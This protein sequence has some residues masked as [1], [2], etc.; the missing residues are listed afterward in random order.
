M[1]LTKLS[2]QV[3]DES[4]VMVALEQSLAMI[5]FN[6]QGDVLWANEN[7]AQAMGYQMS[8]LP[9]IHHQQFCTPDFVNSSEYKTLWDN[10]RK[11]KKF[12]EKIVRVTK[13]GRTLWLEATYMPIYNETEQV[14]AVLKVAT[15]ITAR[16]VA[17]TQ[18]TTELKEL[19]EDLLKRTEEGIKRN[20]Q[21]AMA[22]ERMMNDNEINLN[23]LHN[24]EQQ[25]IAIQRIV[26]TIRDFA[27]QANLLA[28]N[29]A[30]E[31]AHAGEHGRG[32][33]VVATE[34]RKLAK[35]VQESAQEIHSTVEEISEH[36]GRV[37]GGTKTSQQTI[38]DSQHQ[39][40][41]AVSEFAGISEAAGK[42]DAQAKTLSQM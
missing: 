4:A 35:H 17:T 2:T 10:L 20:Q 14:V 28:L 11:G 7:F 13:D 6:T 5:E 42:L 9:G 18:L 25:S 8:E 38:I 27:S 34:V 16:E 41:Q 36:V 3:L 22:I 26:K 19:A 29:A 23:H 24:L 12:Q 40:Q 21:V 32:F 37:S 39:I 1:L 33:N 31:A 30:I 15:N